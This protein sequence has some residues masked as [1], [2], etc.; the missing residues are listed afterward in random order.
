[1]DFQ[2]ILP[3]M[4]FKTQEAA[5]CPKRQ[6]KDNGWKDIRLVV[7]LQKNNVSRLRI[8]L[9]GNLVSQDFGHNFRIADHS[10]R[11]LP[12]DVVTLTKC[13]GATL[14]PAVE[15][16]YAQ[17]DNRQPDRGPDRPNQP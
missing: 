6:S 9:T 2:L 10:L 17:Q 12:T 14:T 7:A 8:Q 16:W 1:M 13:D 4:R 5:R 3:S 15:E 11:T